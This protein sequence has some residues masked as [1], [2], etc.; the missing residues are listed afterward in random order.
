MIF[1]MIFLKEF[2]G[3]GKTTSLVMIRDD[4]PGEGRD[5]S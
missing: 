1:G 3:F 2:L 5:F 4:F